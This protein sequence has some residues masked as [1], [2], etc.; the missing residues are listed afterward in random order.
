MSADDLEKAAAEG[1]TQTGEQLQIPTWTGDSYAMD[2][3]PVDEDFLPTIR[4][5]MIPLRKQERTSALIS[6]NLN[7]WTGYFESDPQN[8]P[9]NLL[10]P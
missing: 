3:E 7:E 4:S 2:W 9:M 8:R 5:Q 1:L 6:S 10:L